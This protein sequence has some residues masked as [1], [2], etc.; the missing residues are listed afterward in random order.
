MNFVDFREPFSAWS[1]CAGFIMAVPGNTCLYL[2]MG[3]GVIACYAELARVISHRAWRLLIRGGLFYS[4]GAAFNALGWPIL[5]PGHFGTHELFH[6]FVLAGSLM[7][8]RLMLDVVG[9][10]ARRPAELSLGST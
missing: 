8:Y 10:F 7:H 1:H 3:W 5:W 9:P 4:A 2:G 6:L